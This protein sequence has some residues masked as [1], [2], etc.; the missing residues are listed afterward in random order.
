MDIYENHLS[1]RISLRRQGQNSLTRG[2][3]KVLKATFEIYFFISAFSKKSSYDYKF[4]SNRQTNTFG[5][6][7]S[8]GRHRQPWMSM[9]NE[10]FMA[11]TAKR[12]IPFLTAYE[13]LYIMSGYETKTF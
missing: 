8:G 6:R 3:Q 2:G 9:S 4:Y 13:K 12:A 5:P 1:M 7:L 10:K 11:R